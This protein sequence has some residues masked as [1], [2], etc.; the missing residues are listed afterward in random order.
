MNK[1]LKF[2]IL[3]EG[4]KNGVSLTCKK[5]NISRTIYY[6]WLKRYQSLG[7]EGLTDVKKHFV[8]LNKTSLIIEEALLALIKTYPKY[9]PKAIKYLAEEI[10]YTISESAVFNVMKRNH[11][12]NKESR[13]RF[14]KK[15]DAT[16]NG[17]IP[18]LEDIKS[19]E[20]WLFSV[21]DYGKFDKIGQIYAYTFFDIKSKI[22]CSRLYQTISFDHF[23]DLLNAV[24]L[25]VART[26]N[27]NT[28]YLCFFEDAKIIQAYKS[29]F[30][31]KLECTLQEN[32]LDAQLHLL[33]PNDDIQKI[34]TLKNNY[35][36][37]C[38][39]FVL[40]FIYK[41]YSFTELKLEFQQHIRA[42][43]T[44]NQLQYEDQTCTPIEFHNQK[45][46]TKFILPLWAYMDRNY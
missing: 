16:P 20:C 3:T 36:E 4:H 7:I 18:D 24:A 15:K 32:G 2:N 21:T 35:T 44:L 11:L 25:P 27:F 14:A 43:N 29:N 45:T 12:T 6:R 19:G 31:S 10:G 17:N 42:Y 8:P 41:D 1:D 34:S 46:H 30:S 28:Q 38:M 5:Y 22:A 33:K 40:P 37:I 13:L 39:S 26:L 9:G 23:E